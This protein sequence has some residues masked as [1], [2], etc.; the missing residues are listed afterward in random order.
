MATQSN[1][2]QRAV[3]LRRILDALS[4]ADSLPSRRHRTRSG[5]SRRSSAFDASIAQ[6]PR[7]PEKGRPTIRRCEPLSLV[8]FCLLYKPALTG[9]P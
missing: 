1:L 3:L 8:I 7:H 9:N 5:P 4:D 6:Y 2:E